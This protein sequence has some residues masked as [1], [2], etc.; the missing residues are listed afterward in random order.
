MAT[1]GPGLFL[2]ARPISFTVKDAAQGGD[3][4]AESWLGVY[5]K[6]Q[7]HYKQGLVWLQK[8]ADQNNAGGEFSLGNAY[9]NGQGVPQNYAKAVYWYQKAAEQ[10]NARAEY[11]LGIAYYH[12]QG[13][14]QNS[15]IAIRWFE[16]A[17]EQFEK[18]AE[19]GEQSAAERAIQIIEKGNAG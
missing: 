2:P 12:G 15:I 5:L 16:K 14:P 11:N 7:H 17:A 18:A 6:A 10:G 19:Q 8:A 3:A 9:A 4:N 13:V 1:R